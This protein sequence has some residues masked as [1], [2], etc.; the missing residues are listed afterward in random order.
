LENSEYVLLQAT[1]DMS[2]ELKIQS[3]QYKPQ[4]VRTAAKTN[5]TK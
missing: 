5:E 4:T 1:N 2:A 3:T